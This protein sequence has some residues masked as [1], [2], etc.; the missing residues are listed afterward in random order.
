MAPRWSRRDFLRLS[1]S[2]LGGAAWL[3]W[4]LPGLQA[5]ALAACRAA[6]EGLPF[7]ILSAAEAREIEA[8][9]ARIFPSDGT[10]G[11]REAGVIHFVDRALGSFAEWAKEP[12]ERGMVDLERAVGER[13]PGTERF[14]DLD[15]E[16]QDAVL[17]EIEEG[18]FFQTV[19]E[20][21]L[22]GLFAHPNRGGNRHQVGWRSLGFEDPGAWQP[23]FGW[24]DERLS[25]EEA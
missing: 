15:E 13:F 12:I 14:S 23:P 19:R 25:E 7:E 2:G 10:P 21:T 18:E 22:M 5:L 3:A 4:R 16:G 1:G 20:L 8:M 6:E 17:R 24:Y 9:V 11:A